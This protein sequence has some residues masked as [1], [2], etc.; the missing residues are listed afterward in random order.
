MTVRPQSTKVIGILKGLLEERNKIKIWSP[1]H[2]IHVYYSFTLD[3]D[4]N[5]RGNYVLI[6]IC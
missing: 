6:L 1:I 3:F 2:S 4:H 5:F